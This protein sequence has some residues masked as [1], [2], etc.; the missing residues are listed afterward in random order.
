MTEEK[1]P[2]TMH[3][4][5][6]FPL[7]KRWM[8]E[9]VYDV[10]E[11][12]QKGGY[13]NVE[14]LEMKEYEDHLEVVWDTKHGLPEEPCWRCEKYCREKDTCKDFIGTEFEREFPALEC[15]DFAERKS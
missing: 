8:A 15:E 6:E 9:F 12:E 14:N 2:Y 13:T 10:V 4:S 7:D 1:F 3:H 11:D 5:A